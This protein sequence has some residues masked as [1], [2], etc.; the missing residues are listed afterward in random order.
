ML[1]SLQSLV[2]SYPT[3]T[4]RADNKASRT[5][6]TRGKRMRA[7]VSFEKQVTHTVAAAL[8]THGSCHA[9]LFT[10][11]SECSA[12]ILAYSTSCSAGDTKSSHTESMRSKRLRASVPFEKKSN[13]TAAVPAT[14]GGSHGSVKG[15]KKP[16]AARM[17]AEKLPNPSSGPRAHSPAEGA[18]M[19]A[20]A[21]SVPRALASHHPVI[22]KY[23][24]ERGFLEP[25]PVQAQVWTEA[26]T[27][28]DVIAQV[29]RQHRARSV[30]RVICMPPRFLEGY[31]VIAQV[32]QQ[33]PSHG[34]D[35]C[36]VKGETSVVLGVPLIPVLAATES[37]PLPSGVE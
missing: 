11:L 19:H 24:T 22:V 18:L 25:T 7:S 35:P 1:S 5:E 16:K 26:L 8:G 15:D 33:C 21:G 28:T 30:V 17:S 12:L 29:C 6:S 36:P 20:S 34:H 32:R 13:P 3:V 4:I 27:G 37:R 9:Q 31:D 2:Q 10:G 14:S 23:M